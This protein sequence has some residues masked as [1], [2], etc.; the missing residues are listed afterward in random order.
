VWSRGAVGV[1]VWTVSDAGP[2]LRAGEAARIGARA[3]DKN[4][5]GCS[6]SLPLPERSGLLR[7]SGRVVVVGG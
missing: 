7:K 5:D 3:G 1:G 6:V 2:A 4:P